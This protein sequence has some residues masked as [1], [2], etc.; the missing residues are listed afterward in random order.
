MTAFKPSDQTWA[1]I[2]VFTGI[3]MVFISKHYG[4]ATD[5]GAGIIGAGIQAYTA[6]AKPKEV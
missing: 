5:I 2:F 4:I 3:C 1:W 6:S